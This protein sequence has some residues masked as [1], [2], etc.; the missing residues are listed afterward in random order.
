MAHHELVDWCARRYQ[1][2]CRP[3]AATAG[4]PGPLPRCR[5]GARIPGHDADIERPDVDAELQRVGRDNRLN[6]AFPQRTFNLAAPLGQVT[7][8]VS[9]NALARACGPVEIVL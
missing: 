4:T 2:R 7:T 1:H 8:S 3:V 9:S 6:G 5:N